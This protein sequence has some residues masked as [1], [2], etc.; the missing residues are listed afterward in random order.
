M[1]AKLEVE[2]RNETCRKPYKVCGKDNQFKGLVASSLDDFKVTACN[3]LELP[4]GNDLK[5][6]LY[7]DMTEVG[8]D[9]YF[10][11]LPAQTKLVVL[12][13]GETAS[14]GMY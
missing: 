14:F 4:F 5:V 13:E 11:F 12:Q 9:E 6:F 2:I 10:Q 1:A 3:A 7:E 8:N